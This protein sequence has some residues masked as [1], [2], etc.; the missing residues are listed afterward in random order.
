MITIIT[1]TC[2]RPEAF[3][4]CQFWMSRQTYS[5]ELQWIVVDDG[6]KPACTTMGQE[7]I[8]REPGKIGHH[9]LK[10]NLLEALPH[11]RGDIVLIIEDDDYYAPNYIETMVSQVSK[12]S[13]AG[14]VGSKYYYLKDRGFVYNNEHNHAS[15]CRTAF[16]SSLIPQVKSIIESMSTS[17]WLVDWELW[18]KLDCDKNLLPS[19]ETGKSICVGIKNLPGKPGPTHTHNTQRG[20]FNLD[21][22][23]N[24]FKDWL[25][26]DWIFYKKYLGMN[27]DD[28]MF[29]TA[30]FD[31]YD[32]LAP[33][34][35]DNM[36]VITNT[37]NDIPSGWNIITKKKTRRNDNRYFKF[38]P[39]LFFRGSP[40]IYFDGS[41]QWRQNPINFYNDVW[42]RESN[43]TVIRHEKSKTIKDEVDAIAGY[44]F[45]TKEN[46]NRHLINNHIDLPVYYGTVLVRQPTD[47]V[48]NFN[49]EVWGQLKNGIRRDQILMPIFLQNVN[50]NV[51]D[52]V[53][54]WGKNKYF[55]WNKNHNV[56]RERV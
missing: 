54:V 49:R 1:P 4:L 46:M 35:Y 56:M 30:V 31:N 47:D 27:N 33:T 9:S 50:Y 40:T 14:E 41:V 52:N 11:V 43:M 32:R 26:E 20:R 28:V 55:H 15:L 29:Y 36:F 53:S 2:D 48:A 16:C 24:R 8:R 5:G 18:W 44:R 10:E 34:T 38:H 21:S 45:D 39:E 37:R 42:D 3:A 6:T 22:S 7:Y 51:V 13:I 23:F 12:R 19:N 17:S 25:G